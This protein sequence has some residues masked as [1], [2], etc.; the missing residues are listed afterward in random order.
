MRVGEQ[1]IFPGMPVSALL[2]ARP[3][4]LRL[5]EAW[6]IDPWLDP[7][8]HLD[9]LAASKRVPWTLF[10]TALDELTDLDEDRDWEGASLPDLLDHLIADHRDMLNRIVPALRIALARIPATEK[11]PPVGSDAAW[12]LFADGLEAHMREEENFLFPRLLHYAYCLRHHGCHPDFDGGSVNVYIAIRLLGNEHRQ[13]EIFMRFLD[14]QEAHVTGLAIGSPDQ[15]RLARL[16][17]EFRI[18]LE[19]HNHL[20]EEVLYPK[21]RDLEKSL[22]DAA[23][24]GSAAASTAS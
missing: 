12:N 22:Y 17:A 3:A 8:A 7:H 2:N 18:R 21:A 13:K 4:A 14:D 23:I 16:L 19:R 6:G 10:E 9:A 15:E 20:E 1:W 24:A 5:L 11:D